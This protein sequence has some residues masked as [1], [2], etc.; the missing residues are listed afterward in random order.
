MR[1][2][3]GFLM[4]GCAVLV[5]PPALGQVPDSKSLV[6]VEQG[7]IVTFDMRQIVWPEGTNGLTAAIV[8][9]LTATDLSSAKSYDLWQIKQFN[10]AFTTFLARVS[11][12]V[13]GPSGGILPT[14]AAELRAAFDVCTKADDEDVCYRRVGATDY[15]NV[16]ADPAAMPV[17]IESKRL[18]QKI[19]RKHKARLETALNALMEQIRIKVASR[20]P[21]GTLPPKPVTI[22][23]GRRGDLNIN[24]TYGATTLTIGEDVV[25][26]VFLRAFFRAAKTLRERNSEM[27]MLEDCSECGE[28]S[29]Q[30]GLFSLNIDRF[31]YLVSALPGLRMRTV[32]AKWFARAVHEGCGNTDPELLAAIDSLAADDD[33]AED[34][35]KDLRELM[36]ADQIRKL[37]QCARADN[38]QITRADVEPYL[39]EY[40]AISEG[41]AEEDVPDE[42]ETYVE[43]ASEATSINV[44]IT[45]ELAKSFT[46]LL[47][48]EG[49]HLWISP[50]AGPQAEYDAD[51]NAAAIYLALFQEIDPSQWFRAVDMPQS[52]GTSGA[53]ENELQD[54]SALFRSIV[55]REPTMLLRE[56]YG[57]TTY[58]EGD[59]LHPPLNDRVA[60]LSAAIKEGRFAYTCEALR[61]M[62]K[63]KNEKGLL[64]VINTSACKLEGDK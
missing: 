64:G 34:D 39:R 45:A 59:V 6:P 14:D 50:N 20:M 12:E 24:A 37:A 26:D 16:L 19:P 33:E 11:P 22:I 9:A 25:R 8:W 54:T 2:L 43:L 52:G 10:Q 63:Q 55:G 35:R 18:R 58:A 60:R 53:D 31:R 29:E 30:E 15:E 41:D 49:Q 42:M 46:F 21:Q 3:L 57:G 7:G 23:V 1:C 51:A 40:A 5:G 48:H 36:P 4:A 17:S 47:G 44:A 27:D 32:S 62:L 28:L 38:V 13:A 56:I 61:A